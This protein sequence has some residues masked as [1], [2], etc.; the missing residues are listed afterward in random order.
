MLSVDR[1]P[2]DDFPYD[3]VTSWE[4]QE[5]L[6][7]VSFERNRSHSYCRN[8]FKPSDVCVDR[9]LWP[10][11]VEL[12]IN[13][14]FWAESRGV[15]R[16]IHGDFGPIE[17]IV[18]PEWNTSFDYRAGKRKDISVRLGSRINYEQNR[19]RLRVLNEI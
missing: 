9:N 19:G 11:S 13:H 4:L 15:T 10:A 5:T 7:A 6:Y 1:R 18:G 2:A 12:L 8:Y 17:L 14:R 3:E 16:S